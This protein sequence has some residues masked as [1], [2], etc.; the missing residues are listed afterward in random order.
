MT[1]E[2]SFIDTEAVSLRAEELREIVSGI[3]RQITEIYS[4]RQEL[5]ENEEERVLLK[6]QE[7]SA[8]ASVQSAENQITAI[9]NICKIYKECD[10]NV[11]AVIYRIMQGR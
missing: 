3:R 6:Q 10:E 9:E 2:K 4:L 8:T 1:G 11:K 5:S 7:A